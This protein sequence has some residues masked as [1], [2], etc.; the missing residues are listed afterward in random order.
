[1]NLFEV[2]VTLRF[3]FDH[4]RLVL[5]SRL[6]LP[7]SKKLSCLRATGCLFIIS[8]KKN[9]NR[10]RFLK[11]SALALLSC[12]WFYRTWNLSPSEFQPVSSSFWWKLVDFGSRTLFLHLVF[13]LD[14]FTCI[15]MTIQSTWWMD[16]YKLWRSHVKC[17][18]I[19]ARQFLQNFIWKIKCN[20]L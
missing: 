1:M 6:M 16:A 17:V 14:G 20:K 13:A 3:S 15:S 4:P 5:V 2:L 8:V 18:S 19:L 11:E 12:C 10:I 9:E 7:S